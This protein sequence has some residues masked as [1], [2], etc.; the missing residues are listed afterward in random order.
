MGHVERY[1]K[2]L[3]V[4][5]AKQA[6]CKEYACFPRRY[7]SILDLWFPTKWVPSW[8]VSQHCILRYKTLC[9]G[10][11]LFVS[12]AILLSCYD[13]V[14]LGVLVGGGPR[15][16]KGSKAL[17]VRSNTLVLHGKSNGVILGGSVLWIL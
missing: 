3:D 17:H 14:E 11:I 12:T 15:P 2:A 1:R 9:L 4:E 6:A 5:F 16:P 7:T 13:C 10:M 8:G